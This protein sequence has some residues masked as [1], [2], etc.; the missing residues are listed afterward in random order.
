MDLFF[1]VRDMSSTLFL[2]RDADSLYLTPA[3]LLPGLSI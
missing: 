1:I 2:L 3:K